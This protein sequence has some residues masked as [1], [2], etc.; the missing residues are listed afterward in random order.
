MAEQEEIPRAKVWWYDG[1]DLENEITAFVHCQRCLEE[2]PEDVSPADWSRTQTGL[3]STGEIQV[4][5]NRHDIN[6]NLFAFTE[7]EV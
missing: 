5:C 7:R 6:V 2:L 1:S 4:W 3:T